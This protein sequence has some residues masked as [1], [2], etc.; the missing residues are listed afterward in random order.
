V[1]PTRASQYFG[2]NRSGA[3]HSHQSVRSGV[4]AIASRGISVFVQV[5]STI[6][7]ARLL[8]P[9]DFGL[10]SMVAAFTGFIPV[11]SDLGTRDAAVQRA[12]ITQHEVSALFWLTMAIGVALGLLLAAGGPLIASYYHEPRLRDIALA[13]SL[14]FMLGA[15]SCQHFALLRR[16]MQFKAIAS[17]EVGANVLSSVASIAM[18]IWGA[19]YWAL[20]AKPVLLAAF[21]LI[22]VGL[23]CPW[24]PGIP[25]LTAGVRE[26]VK[27]GMH[28]TGFTVTDYVSRAIDRVAIGRRNGAAPLGYYQQCLFI[29]ENVLG[30]LSISLHPVAVAGLSKLTDNLSE[31]KRAWSKAISTL[32][33]FAMPAFGLLAVTSE[34]VVTLV[35]GEKWRYTATLVAIM[36]LRGI[37]H[38]V[39][40]TLGWLHVPAGRGDRWMR[41]GFISAAVQVVALFC[42]LPFGIEG[43]VTSYVIAMFL[44]CVPAIAYAGKPVGI[45]AGDLVKAIG[46]PFAGTVLMCAVGFLLDQFVFEHSPGLV[47]VAAVVTASALTYL[48]MVVVILKK[49]EPLE[50]VWRTARNFRGRRA[51][52]S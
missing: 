8:S 26:M 24:V 30:L 27:F 7:L 34:D 17:I 31:F 13:S 44:L 40:R 2:D 46:A 4:F 25:S 22:G 18:A 10:V 35:L 9:E 39:E 41:W 15:A 21:T 52:A 6:I 33:F 48:L 47:R 1:N 50:L 11:L 32:A 49:R 51:A 12:A 36:A 3:D 19:G 42:G 38:C 45:G 29:Y 5:G 14:G 28:I 37:P 23:A 16:A 43:V 20:V